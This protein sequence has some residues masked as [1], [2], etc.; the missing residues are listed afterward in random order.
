LIIFRKFFQFLHE[1]GLTK[2]YYLVLSSTG[3]KNEV[4]I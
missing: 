3:C 1:V 2:N 4:L